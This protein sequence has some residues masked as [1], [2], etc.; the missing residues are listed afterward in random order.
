ML[1]EAE[2]PMVEA[3]CQHFGRDP[4]FQVLHAEVMSV[5][6]KKDFGRTVLARYMETLAN[7]LKHQASIIPTAHAQP[8]K[9]CDV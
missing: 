9:F 3:G 2:Q 5:A 1:R 4:V 7:A 8:R 6:N